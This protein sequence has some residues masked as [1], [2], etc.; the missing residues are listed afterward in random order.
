MPSAFGPRYSKRV[1]EIPCTVFL[2]GCAPAPGSPGSPAEPSHDFVNLDAQGNMLV[3]FDDNSLGAHSVGPVITGVPADQITLLL[4]D[5]GVLARN[6]S[7]SPGHRSSGGFH[8]TRLPR[9]PPPLDPGTGRFVLAAQHRLQEGNAP[10]TFLVTGPDAELRPQMLRRMVAEGHEIGNQ[11]WNHRSFTSL[12]ASRVRREIDRTNNMVGQAAGQ[13]ATFLRRPSVRTIQSA[14]GSRAGRS[15]GGMSTRWSGNTA[16]PGSWLASRLVQTR[17]GEIVLMRGIHPS[18]L[19]TVPST[20]SGLRAKD[21][22]FVTVTEPMGASGLEAGESSARAPRP[23]KPDIGERG[24][25]G[26]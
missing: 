1:S 20:F 5:L 13:P 8:R 22:T 12:S 9:I 19:A 25:G 23:A 10:S 11:T 17:P 2:A 26:R 21:Y 4:S 16:T 24:K 3:E 6:A 15:S 14:T 18:T 7:T